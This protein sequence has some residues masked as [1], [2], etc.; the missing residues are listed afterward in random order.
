MS[1][2]RLTPRDRVLRVNG[3]APSV[4]LSTN[5]LSRTHWSERSSLVK[6]ERERWIWLLKQQAA[7]IPRFTR[8]VDVAFKVRFGPDP[9]TGR[10]PRLD[11]DGL[12]AVCKTVLDVLTDGYAGARPWDGLGLFHDDTTRCVGIVSY[13]VDATPGEPYLEITLKETR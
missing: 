2:S 6:A 9:F 3:D 5:L 13:E 1:P 4:R 8:P 11:P 10:T 7:A 12:A